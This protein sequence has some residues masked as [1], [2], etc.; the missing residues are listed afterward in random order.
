MNDELIVFSHNDADALGSML[1]IEFKMPNIR[2]K[3]FHTNYAN[4]KEKV[5]EIELYIK[6]NGNTHILI[7][8]VSFSTAREQLI[9]L[10]KLGKCTL[11]DH[12]LYPDN[13]FDDLDL[14]VHHCTTKSATLLC[15]EYFGNTGKNERLD[16]LT[17]IIDVYDLWQVDSPY[18]KVAQDFNNY[19]WLNSIDYLFNEIVNND[20]KLPSNYTET[21]KNF[22][23]NAENSIESYRK[24]NLICTSGDITLA[25]VDDY[26]NQ[27]LVKEMEKGINF[28]IN[29][30]SFG[31]IKIRINKNGNFKKEFL[32][33]LRIALTGTKDIGHNLAFTYKMQKQANFNNL[34]E[35]IKKVTDY[36][37]ELR[38][39]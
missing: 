5:D 36:I 10:T 18:F 25:F 4:I 21:V 35:E 12:H 15:N 37:T 28:V 38:K 8:D 13:F 14:K 3:Y 17:Q 24:R 34:M 29:A 39:V 9:R 22:N 32:D 6:Q 33:E 27:I 31:I 7:P 30:T 16:K 2:K 20:Y 11:I 23:I 19:F 26:F 1:N